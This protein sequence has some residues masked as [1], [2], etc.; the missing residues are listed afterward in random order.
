MLPSLASLRI[1]S[2]TYETSAR[3]TQTQHDDDVVTVGVKPNRPNT[4]MQPALQGR[5]IQK[6]KAKKYDLPPGW[7]VRKDDGVDKPEFVSPDG[8][9]F[10]FSVK[11]AWRRARTHSSA[12]TDKTQL[13][14]GWTVRSYGI[15]KPEYVSPDGMI[16][17]FSVKEAWRRHATMPSAVG[18]TNTQT[19]N[20][21]PDCNLSSS[22]AYESISKHM[23]R[24]RIVKDM[25]K[26][27]CQTG[28]SPVLVYIAAP[29]GSDSTYFDQEVR[30]NPSLKGT[31]LIAVNNGRF[32]RVRGNIDFGTQH[33]EYV[34]GT[35]MHEYLNNASEKAFTHT[36]LDTTNVDIECK[37]YWNANRTTKDMVYIV[38]SLRA[39]RSDNLRYVVSTRCKFFGFRITHE[40]EYSGVSSNGP[41]NQINMVFVAA[42]VLSQKYQKSYD[43]LFDR[44]GC[45]M[46]VPVVNV[47]LDSSFKDGIYTTSKNKTAQAVGFVTHYDGYY[48]MFTLILFNRD[49]SLGNTAIEVHRSRVGNYSAWTPKLT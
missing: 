23:H 33:V 15:D 6:P 25:V 36:W 18:P 11:D 1:A 37:T 20:S 12:S 28:E 13:P 34:E 9:M 29:D 22:G 35:Q 30:S 47:E 42:N 19:T 3:S 14:P 40:E 27:A 7:T 32:H 16:F 41:S 17:V 26:F 5:G 44:I 24:V 4:R 39:Q 43:P 48:N 21:L 49:R 45:I 46:D 31:R 38:L 8:Q 10:V 2:D